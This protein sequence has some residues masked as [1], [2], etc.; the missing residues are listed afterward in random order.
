MVEFAL[1]SPVLV[2][3]FLGLIFF[4][5]DFL[6]YAQLEERVRAGARLGSVQSYDSLNNVEPS[7]TCGTCQLTL[8]TSNS[9]I[10]Q[11][12]KGLVVYGTPFPIGNETPLVPGLTYS[13]VNLRVI[14]ENNFPVGMRVGIINY[15]MLTPMGQ[16]TL[17]NKPES[18]FPY[19]G[20][21]ATP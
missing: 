3:L 14:V 11:R 2:G 1:L 4:G 15:R 19:F 9:E 16:V 17:N 10:A 5:N 6:V 8:V 12:V 20:R 13:N 21:V 18:Q 7:L